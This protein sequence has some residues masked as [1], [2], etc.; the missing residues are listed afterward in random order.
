MASS[1]PHGYPERWEYAFGPFTLDPYREVLSCHGE[2]IRLPGQAFALLHALI[3]ANGSVVLREELASSIW[4][5]GG[6]TES[7]LSQHVYMLRRILGERA[8]DRHFI[9]T[10]RGRGFRFVA[11]VSVVKSSRADKLMPRRSEGACGDEDPF[12]AGYDAFRFYSCA[13]VL[14][15]RPTAVTLSAAIEHFAAA[16][17]IDSNF[18]PALVGTARAHALLA[19]NYYAAGEWALPRAFDAIERALILSPRSASAHAVRSHVALLA[20]WDWHAAASAIET[21]MALSPASI[22]VRVSAMWLYEYAGDRARAS[23]ELQRALLLAPY[24]PNLQMLLGRLLVLNGEY[25]PAIAH[26]SHLLKIG[27]EFACARRHR[28][29]ALILAGRFRE[30]IGDLTALPNDAAEDIAS[31]LPLLSR[32]HAEAGDR[33]QAADIYEQLLNASRN[34]FVAHGNLAI[35]AIGLELYGQALHHLE[36]A[37]LAREPSMLSLRVSPWYEPVRSSQRFGRLLDEI[38]T[39]EHALIR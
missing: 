31:R 19:Q 18:T 8:S 6:V 5:E 20:R 26:F 1:L 12:R 2:V 22:L 24:S 34:E 29:E 38:G 10:V 7:N 36:N 4:A 21:A 9:M 3:A 13:S 27:P 11:P 39:F 16:L 32:A 33:K 37:F 35:C 15:E 17:A 28:A 25:E 23:A 14:L 30:A